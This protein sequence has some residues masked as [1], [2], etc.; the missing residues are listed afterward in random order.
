MTFFGK[1]SPQEQLLEPKGDEYSSANATRPRRKLKA[2]LALLTVGTL[3]LTGM[4][5]STASQEEPLHTVPQALSSSA[6]H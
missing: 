5:M 2:G 6:E 1:R 4:L 3:A